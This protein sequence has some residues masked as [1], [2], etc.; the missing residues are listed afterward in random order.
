MAGTRI[1]VVFTQAAAADVLV[2][3]NPVQM[4]D[5]RNT[6]TDIRR[7]LSA[8]CGGY[9]FVGLELS[10][11]ET[12]WAAL[13][14]DKAEKYARSRKV[15]VH[16]MLPRL[17]TQVG[18]LQADVRTLKADVRTLTGQVNGLV[19]DRDELRGDRSNL[20]TILQRCICTTSRDKLGEQGGRLRLANG[21]FPTSFFE[22]VNT[23][24]VGFLAARNLTPDAISVI[25]GGTIHAGDDLV[26][27]HDRAELLRGLHGMQGNLLR[28]FTLLLDYAV[29]TQ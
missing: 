10:S 6:Q 7:Q 8:G 16:S 14:R 4:M 29:G 20:F 3:L 18:G 1:R 9:S 21:K 22:W 26:H 5:S 13:P 28:D 2:T 25:I 24:P 12:V 23:L 15:Y 27:T 19:R 17:F 11:D